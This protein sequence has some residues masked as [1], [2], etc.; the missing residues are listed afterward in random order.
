MDR[1]DIRSQSF[2]LSISSL[3]LMTNSWLKDDS[4]LDLSNLGL[5]LAAAGEGDDDMIWEGDTKLEDDID[6]EGEKM[7]GAGTVP[8]VSPFTALAINSS[9]NVLQGSRG[10]LLLIL[11]LFTLLSRLLILAG[12]M[13]LSPVSDLL[14]P[15]DEQRLRIMMKAEM[16]RSRVSRSRS[17]FVVR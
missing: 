1:V 3:L 7:L 9:L 8:E 14:D 15:R 17:M 13:L 12:L 5:M 16:I 11:E 4:L 6:S 2:S 10:L